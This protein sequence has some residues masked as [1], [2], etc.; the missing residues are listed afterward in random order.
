M[1]Q[2]VHGIVIQH[3][4]GGELVAEKDAEPADHHI[5]C[6]RDAD[7]IVRLDGFALECG[8]RKSDNLAIDL[9]GGFKLRISTTNFLLL[10]IWRSALP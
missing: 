2:P 4:V 7:L 9:C 3:L 10:A 8:L 6:F 5:H 1:H